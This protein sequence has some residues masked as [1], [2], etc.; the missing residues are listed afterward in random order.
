MQIETAAFRLA[1]LGH[2]QRLRIFSQLV[3]AGPAGMTIG[4]V[5]EVLDRPMSTVAFH[6]RELVAAGLVDQEKQ[7]RSVHCRASFAALNE[8]LEFVTSECCQGAS[9]SI[10]SPYRS[11]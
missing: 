8:L 3:R 9:A 4:Q 2:E 1:S 6:L 10:V 7:G 11:A 5:R